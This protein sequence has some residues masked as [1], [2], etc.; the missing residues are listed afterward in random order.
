MGVGS[1]I[2]ARKGVHIWKRMEKK[3][4]MPKPVAVRLVGKT[5]GK[6]LSSML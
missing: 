2:V 6:A 4:T 3:W 1:L 5:A